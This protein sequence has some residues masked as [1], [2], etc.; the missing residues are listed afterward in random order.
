[1]EEWRDIAGYEGLYQV[2]NMGRVRSLDRYVPHKT[3][4]TKFCKGVTMRTHQTNAGYLAVNLSKENKYT[5]F[6][7][8]RIVAQAFIKNPDGLP[9][10]NHK[11]ENKHNNAVDNLEWCDSYYNAIYGTKLERQ[12]EKMSR[13]IIQYDKSGN[14]LKEYDSATQAEKEISGKLTGA[15][16]KCINGR[17]K[18]AYGYIWKY[19]EVT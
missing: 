6:D 13:P 4:G 12:K 3:F 16:S 1:M 7:V 8:H 14:P 18:T 5:T 19:K 9:E 11:D 15:I 10:V 17:S 2:S